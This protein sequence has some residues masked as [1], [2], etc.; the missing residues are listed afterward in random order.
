MGLFKG[1]QK[2]I[3]IALMAALATAPATAKTIRSAAVIAAFKRH[4][5]CPSTGLRRGACPGY[6]VDHIIPLCAG[7]PDEEPNLQWQTREDAL[8]KDKQERKQC[9]NLTQSNITPVQ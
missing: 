4:N 7:G 2:A 9:R 5:P 1:A 6:T 8:R 3:A